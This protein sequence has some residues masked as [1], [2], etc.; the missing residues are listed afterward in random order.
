[1]IYYNPFTLNAL[2]IY[3]APT[4]ILIPESHIKTDKICQFQLPSFV[5]NEI[6]YKMGAINLII[7]CHA[8]RFMKRFIDHE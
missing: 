3:R 8:A 2:E 6:F 5:T 1:M 4:K 7:P